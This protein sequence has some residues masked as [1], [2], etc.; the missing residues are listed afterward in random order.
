MVV[1]SLL[2]KCDIL[3]LQE[4]FLPKQDLGLLNSFNGS[5]HGAGESTT[6]LSLGIVRGRIAGGV[7]IV[8]HEKLDSVINI[9]RLNVDWC[10]AIQL[11]ISNKIFTILN[12]YTP[13]ECLNNEDEYMNRLA[14][15]HSFIADNMSTQC[16]CG[17]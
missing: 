17:R 14:F 16:L 3:C 6:D 5:F 10:I 12:V 4:T 11:K 15:I 1:D 7:A 2:L 9:L 8:W 13:F